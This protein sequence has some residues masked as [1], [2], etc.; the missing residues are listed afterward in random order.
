MPQQN[1]KDQ[2]VNVQS[3]QNQTGGTGQTT[4]QPQT[5]GSQSLA[6]Q[7]D[8]QIQQVKQQLATVSN[9][10][11]KQVSDQLANLERN[12]L[13]DKIDGELQSLR[14]SADDTAQGNKQ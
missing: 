10:Q 11:L 13:L 8:G 7:L 3:Q 14:E 12:V 4:Q 1:Q 9:A 6:Q 2:T 5:D